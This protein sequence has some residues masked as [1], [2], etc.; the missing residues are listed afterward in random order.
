MSDQITINF[1]LVK[2]LPPE[3]KYASH[4]CKILSGLR[5]LFMVGVTHKVGLN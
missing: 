5:L 1:T 3:G 2:I 4:C